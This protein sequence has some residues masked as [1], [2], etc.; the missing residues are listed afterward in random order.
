MYAQASLRSVET[1]G[2]KR[3][4]TVFALSKLTS[5]HGK[6]LIFLTSL[7]FQLIPVVD[8]RAKD[9]EHEAIQKLNMVMDLAVDS[10]ALQLP[11]LIRDFV[12][13]D[14]NLGAL[15]TQEQLR[16]VD[17]ERANVISERIVDGMSN[18][19]RYGRRTDMIDDVRQ[20]I[21]RSNTLAAAA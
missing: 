13:R 9:L 6:K 21:S 10:K 16:D 1:G 2:F 17:N 12:W 8:R 11:A 14:S 3:R 19:L 20:M 5:R 15:F 4:M 18:W 7:Y